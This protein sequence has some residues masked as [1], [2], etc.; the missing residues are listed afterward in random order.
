[1]RNREGVSLV[2]PH[3]G[4]LL[5]SVLGPIGSVSCGA[6]PRPAHVA[7]DT[8]NS[9]RAVER[10]LDDLHAAAAKGDDARYLAHFA[11][12]AVFLGTDKSERWDL[13]T[14]ADYVHTHFQKAKVEGGR[15]VPA[16]GWTYSVTRRAVSFSAD[17][18]TA[19]FDEDLVGEKAG[20]TR[21][22]GVLVRE[23]G[24][25]LVAQYNLTFTIPNARFE[26]M[27]V[28][29]KAEP[30]PTLGE[31]QRLVYRDA[32]DAATKGDLPL[33]LDLLGSL[34]VLAKTHP[35]D[36][37]EFWLHNQLTWIHWAS[38]NLERALDEV[39]AAGIAVDHST[40]V[41]KTS[42]RLHER[43]D[44]AYLLLELATKAP[45]DKRLLGAANEAHAAYEALA[46]PADDRN[47]MAVLDAFFLTRAGK[48][49][50]AAAA[51]KRVDIEKDS[52]LQDLY[53]IAMALDANGEREAALRVAARV[54]NGYEYLMKPLLVKSMATTWMKCGG[55][56][57]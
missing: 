26:A 14:F 13:P 37:T 56:G 31:R 1:M 44:R 18:M 32:T 47:G 48:G 52:D 11:R 54:C 22:S 50:L 45:A 49:K 23:G 46:K 21:G 3:L 53:V 4:V 7:F 39:N 17:G 20:E 40:I 34:V 24:R 2:R 33:A 10:E 51:A 38:G 9:E 42:L 43:W 5:L 41:D 30:M 57:P 19:W 35:E 6:P 12:S 36:D 55:T 28:A 27:R 25:Y 8:K 15:E 16:K 29:I